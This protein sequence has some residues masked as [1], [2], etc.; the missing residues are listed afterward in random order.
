MAMGAAVVFSFVPHF[1][2][3][4]FDFDGPGGGGYSTGFSAWHRL[5]GLGGLA[6]LC[7]VVLAIVAASL[8]TSQTLARRLLAGMS[9]AISLVAGG[10]FVLYLL[11]EQH[12]SAD[13]IRGMD[14]GLGWSG[15]VVLGLTA[16][17]TA[18]A[19][20]AALLADEVTP[21]PAHPPPPWA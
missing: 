13:G 4:S 2:T 16:V 15:F 19:V 5:G 18:V 8:P 14:F 10:L 11:V 7:G 6:L 21:G 17:A 9:G 12:D 1:L 3:V 20:V